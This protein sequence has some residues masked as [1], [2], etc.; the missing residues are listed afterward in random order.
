MGA[1]A[2]VGVALAAAVL[3]GVGFVLQQQVAQRM[4][5][6][7]TLSW[8]LFRDLIGKRRWLAGIASMVGGQV[9]GA[10]ALGLATITVV[11]PLLTTNLLFALVLAW[12]LSEQS[13][14]WYEWLGALALAAGVALFVVAADPRSGHGAGGYRLW[15][16][17][18]VVVLFCAAAVAVGRRATGGRRAVGLATA[19]STLYGLQDGFTR[20]GMLL[21]DHGVARLLS[22]W[23]PYALVSVAV[24]GLLLAQSAFEA[25]PLRLSLPVM[26]VV[27]PG[28]GIAYGVVV[29]GDTVRSGLPWSVL[30]AVALALAVAGCVLVTR[31]PVLVEGSATSSRTDPPEHRP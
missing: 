5:V 3:L 4:P 20:R 31:S 29:S 9:L 14:R 24:V 15:L 22:T 2:P 11:E 8:R 19:A 6:E 23:T 10:V 27:E 28:V 16:F 21:L 7:D 12:V 26:S 17:V 13:L 1:G 18:G 25:A 30:Q